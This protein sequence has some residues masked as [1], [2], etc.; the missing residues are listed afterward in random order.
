MSWCYQVK[1]K[2]YHWITDLYD[3]LNLPVIPAIVEALENEVVKRMKDIEKTKTDKTKKNRVQMKVARVEDQL[4][5]KK[6]VKKQALLHSYG[7]DS[8]GDDDDDD[9]DDNE[10]D[11]KQRTEGVLKQATKVKIRNCRCGSKEHM[12]VSHSACPLNSKNN[13]NMNNNFPM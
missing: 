5:R 6:W 4:E 7:K 11:A 12:R 3:R 10:L 13:K 8:D 9:E 1:G 2:S